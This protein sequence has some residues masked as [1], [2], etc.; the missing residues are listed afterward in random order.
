MQ[1]HESLRFLGSR[2]RRGFPWPVVGAWLLCGA[3]RTGLV[4]AAFEAL[5]AWETALVQ[6]GPCMQALLGEEDTD[7]DRRITIDD[8]VLGGRGDRRF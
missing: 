7:R 6:V 4:S 1:V 2:L 8:P 3:C 5:G